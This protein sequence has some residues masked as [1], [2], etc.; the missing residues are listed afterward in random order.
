MDMEKVHKMTES[1][2]VESYGMT[3][4]LK[5]IAGIG[6]FSIP[7]KV[8]AADKRQFLAGYLSGC[9]RRTEWKNLDKNALIA[10]AQKELN[11]YSTFKAEK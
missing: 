5:F 4:E 7:K 10:F 9:D 6:S 3:N 1:V 11:I 2:G 8:S